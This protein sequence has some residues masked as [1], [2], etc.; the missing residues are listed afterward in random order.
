M[1]VQRAG[2]PHAQAY[3]G[4]CGRSVFDAFNYDYIIEYT[5]HEDGR[6]TMRSG[7]TGYNLPSNTSEPHVHNGFGG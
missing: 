2:Q 6:I 7:A 3:P 4:G 1:V 5:F